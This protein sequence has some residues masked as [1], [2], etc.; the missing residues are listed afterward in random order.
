MQV[1]VSNALARAAQSRG[2]RGQVLVEFAIIALVLYLLLAGTFEFGRAIYSAEV[3]QH[4]ADVCA[5]ELSRTPLKADSSFTDALKAP[6]VAQQVY[7]P[8]KLVLVNPPQ[9]PDAF[10]AYVSALPI[11]NQ[12]LITLMVQD[13]VE[14]QPVLR[15]PGAIAKGQQG[16]FP[17]LNSPYTVVIP[18]VSRDAAGNETFNNEWADVVE[19]IKD[20]ADAMS[21]FSI[22]SPKRGIVAL[23]FNYP[24]QAA[25]L[26]AYGHGASGTENNPVQ[27]NASLDAIT[28][29]TSYGVNVALVAPDENDPLHQPTFSG[30]LGLGKQYAMTKVV[31]P[32]RKVLSAQAIYRREVFN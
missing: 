19:E 24:Y 1:V 27:V 11:V 12:Q 20:P 21:P 25:T 31:R 28:S 18:L 22:A 23:R 16:T 26:T 29:A 2:R 17:F 9:D 13:V 8:S 7:D 10:Q 3:L 6:T 14:G 30:T 32:Y 4:T 15:Y 5:R